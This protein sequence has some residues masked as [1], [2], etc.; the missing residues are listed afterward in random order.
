MGKYRIKVNSPAN[1]ETLL[2]ETYDLAQ[3]HLNL[4]LKEMNKL[5]ESVDLKDELI[6]GKGKYAKAMHDFISD[7]D[8]A[9]GRLIDI[10]KMLNEVIKYNGDAD[11]ALK[12]KELND[13]VEN[14]YDFSTVRDAYNGGPNSE[15]EDK[16]RIDY[17]L[18]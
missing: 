3:G 8:K 11:K 15:N 14:D 10:A 6:D 13:S 1:L 7:R 9:L 2:Q 18:K 17:E 12:S 5:S 4:T 16:K